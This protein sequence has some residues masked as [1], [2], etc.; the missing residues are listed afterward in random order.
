MAL[1]LAKFGLVLGMLL[2]MEGIILTITMGLSPSNSRAEST[3]RMANDGASLGD[4]EQ[5]PCPT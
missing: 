2:A 1:G 5:G 4:Q 3:T